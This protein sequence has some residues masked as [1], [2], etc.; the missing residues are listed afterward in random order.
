MPDRMRVADFLAVRGD[1]E[2]EDRFFTQLRLRNG[3]F[4]MTRRHRFDDTF[5]V[6]GDL[7]ERHPGR[8]LDIACSSGVSTVELAEA[9]ARR[10][11]TRDV[12]GTDAVIHARYLERA[13]FGVLVDSHSDVLQ[14]DHPGWAIPRRPGRRDLALTP[15]RAVHAVA[16]RAYVLAGATRVTPIR[17]RLVAR[18]S[19]RREVA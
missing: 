18:G 5:A 19:E 17:S 15:W 2:A 3:V 6:T 9:I 16:I 12:H 1:L 7:V 10:G 14:I 13:D 11:L 4:K 8:V